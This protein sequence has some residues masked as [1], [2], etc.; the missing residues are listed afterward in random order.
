M[1]VDD[2][3]LEKARDLI[4]KGD[5][6]VDYLG[7]YMILLQA[8]R[9]GWPDTWIAW[10]ER[11]HAVLTQARRDETHAWRALSAAEPGTQEADGAKAAHETAMRRTSNASRNWRRAREPERSKRRKVSAKIRKAVVA[12]WEASGRICGIC[13][14]PVGEEDAFHVYHDLPTS[15]GGTSEKE[16]LRVGH[17]RC[18]SEFGDGSILHFRARERFRVRKEAEKADEGQP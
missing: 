10:A 4:E 18:N 13:R 1:P 14:N 9:E 12:E 3:R 2:V 8:N 5:R 17:A 7:L 6:R 15:A 11:A 16:N